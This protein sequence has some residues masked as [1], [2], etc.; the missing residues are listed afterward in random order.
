[1]GSMCNCLCTFTGKINNKTKTKS[2]I[3]HY[4]KMTKPT[5]HWM[6]FM[7]PVSEARIHDCRFNP[8]YPHEMSIYH[9]SLGLLGALG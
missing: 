3:L 4:F 8:T 7:V 2:R 6:T 9:P 5:V 1:M